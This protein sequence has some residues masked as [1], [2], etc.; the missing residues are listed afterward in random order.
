[1]LSNASSNIDNF[2]GGLNLASLNSADHYHHPLVQIAL[3]AAQP[4]DGSVEPAQPDIPLP[5]CV[6]CTGAIGRGGGMV[7]CTVAA[8]PDE[9][10][11]GIAEDAGITHIVTRNAFASPHEDS[12]ENVRVPQASRFA[13]VH[14]EPAAAESYASLPRCGR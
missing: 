9:D 13:V 4:V 12:A 14:V 8:R 6:R 11:S 3:S 10:N 2:L 5:R 7:P 1:M